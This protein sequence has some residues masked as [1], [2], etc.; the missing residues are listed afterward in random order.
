VKTLAGAA[1]G[2]VG[3]WFGRVPEGDKAAKTD[4]SGGIFFRKTGGHGNETK[5][6]NNPEYGENIDEFLDVA[7]G[8]RA[9]TGVNSGNTLAHT[10]NELSDA[11]DF[12]KALSRTMG[13]GLLD[14][15]VAPID[16]SC[17]NKDKGCGFDGKPHDGVDYTRTYQDGSGDTVKNSNK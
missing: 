2:A 5:H 11:H 15:T 6:S 12:G 7:A 8:W 4:V 1:G 14:K 13:I 10:A 9:V 17:I 16:S 3:S